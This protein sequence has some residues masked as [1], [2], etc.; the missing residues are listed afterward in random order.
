MSEEKKF[1]QAIEEGEQYYVNFGGK[2]LEVDI[3]AMG[4]DYVEA[5]VIDRDETPEAMELKGRK[6]II[7]F[8]ALIVRKK[9]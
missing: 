7:H 6:W 3:V 4:Y 5:E 8:A 1:K 9:G 2:I